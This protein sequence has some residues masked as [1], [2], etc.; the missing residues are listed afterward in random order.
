[1]NDE[2]EKDLVASKKDKGEVDQL[3]FD[4]AMNR[5][6]EV[7][8][9]IE[10]LP[11]R[12][13]GY[14]KAAEAVAEYLEIC[15]NGK[16]AEVRYEYKTEEGKKTVDQRFGP[17]DHAMWLE[18]ADRLHHPEQCSRLEVSYAWEAL[19]ERSSRFGKTHGPRFYPELTFGWAANYLVSKTGFETGGPKFH[20]PALR[21]QILFLP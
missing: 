16:I 20:S 4:Q 11:G 7:G 2:A 21:G 6:I 9:E 15:A 18:L 8:R 12:N 3:P 14:R 1:M 19:H 5:L 13:E 17:Q 10:G